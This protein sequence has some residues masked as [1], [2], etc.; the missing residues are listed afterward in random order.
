MEKAKAF[1]T[2]H[3]VDDM[4]ESYFIDQGNRLTINFAARQDDV[5]CYPD[6]I[7]VEVAMDNGEIVGYEAAGYL[8]NHTQRSSL[9]PWVAAGDAQEQVSGELSVLSRQLALIP[10]EGENE[11]LCWEFKCE[12]GDGKHYIVYINAKTGEE[13]Q[14][15]ILLEDENGTLTL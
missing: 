9:Q 5:I 14:I 10:T 4:A 15:L 2:A 11:V 12:N 1:L 6:L 3:G 8:M 13:Q 7:K